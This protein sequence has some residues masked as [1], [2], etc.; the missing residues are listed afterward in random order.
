[1]CKIHAHYKKNS[2]QACSFCE[3]QE[4][5]PENKE[6]ASLVHIWLR[7]HHHLP[8]ACFWRKLQNFQASSLLGNAQQD[9]VLHPQIHCD[10]SP[11][12]TLGHQFPPLQEMGLGANRASPCSEWTRKESSMLSCNGNEVS[13]SPKWKVNP[14]EH[15]GSIADAAQKLNRWILKVWKYVK[16]FEPYLS[17]PFHLQISSFPTPSA[18]KTPMKA[19][20]NF[21]V[22]AS[23]VTLHS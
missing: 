10:R 7:F 20:K 13:N 11:R 19:S 23:G 9:Q 5:P 16:D 3:F 21:A 14:T 17:I 2:L 12:S 8:I 15:Q 6:E 18:S 4:C 22:R 1:M